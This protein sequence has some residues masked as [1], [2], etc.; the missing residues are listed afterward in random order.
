MPITEKRVARE[1]RNLIYSQ[2]EFKQV[3]KNGIWLFKAE[4]AK[5]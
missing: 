3:E 2:T 4:S 1:K 5:I